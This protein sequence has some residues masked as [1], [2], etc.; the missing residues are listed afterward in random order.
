M[1]TIYALA[2]PP[3]KSGVAVIRISGSDAFSLAHRLT[4][5]EL[6]P[7]HAHFLALKN[8]RGEVLDE[9]VVL[10]F[11]APASFT[12]EDVVELQIHG[13]RASIQAVSESLRDMG[14]RL[15]AAGEFTRRALENGKLDML[16]VEA[17]A[18]FINSD[19]EAQRKGALTGYLGRDSAWVDGLRETLVQSM[20]LV[21]LSIDFV[22]EELPDDLMAQIQSGLRGI[23]EEL[24]AEIKRSE[25]SASLKDGF[26]VAILGR[27][28][29][30]KSSLLNA[31]AGREIA[32]A[33]EIPGTTRDVIEAFVDL[34]GLPVIFM[35]TA[36]I[37][38]TAD[39]VEGI[40]V[41]RAMDAARGAD[42]RVFLYENPDELE[43]FASVRREGDLI[44]QSK[45]D[46]YGA[47]GLA[48]SAKSGEGVDAL[49]EHVKSYFAEITAE[50]GRFQ[51]QRQIDALREAYDATDQAFRLSLS[52]ELE[53]DLVAEYLRR[54][55]FALD[56]LVGRVDV[57]DM[58]DVIF[59]Q[60]C[61]GK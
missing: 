28:N 16:Q 33:T 19:T 53:L 9:A 6:T 50:L 25:R 38:E 1:D 44:V 36:G 34:D 41:E 29:V 8:T 26:R 18:D 22:D 60:F 35:D 40:G 52:G 11:K 42:L 15:A 54:A 47:A 48:L 12:G 13:S 55:V 3:G 46:V 31:I 57:E 17:L 37:R 20:S 23:S 5:A 49:L 7:R 24:N 58:L 4:G 21:T 45:S 10:G 43:D 2:T 27:P 30:G 61:I 56:H 14:A 59:S 32:I 51:H 39:V